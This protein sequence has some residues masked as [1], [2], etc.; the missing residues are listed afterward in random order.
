MRAKEE[1]RKAKLKENLGI[2]NVQ[3]RFLEDPSKLPVKEV[4][5]EET[6]PKEKKPKRGSSMAP[7]R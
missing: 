1:K 7:L 2:V 5:I 6:K 3:S 4:I